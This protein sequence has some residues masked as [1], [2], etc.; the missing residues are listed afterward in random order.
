MSNGKKA[1]IGATLLVLIAAGIRIG[2][3]YRE[4]NAPAV[5]A[6]TPEREKLTDHWPALL[7]R[8]AERARET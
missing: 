4:R 8:A 7:L 6:P 1:A 3:I 2:M 5:Q